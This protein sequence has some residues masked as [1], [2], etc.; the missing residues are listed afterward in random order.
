MNGNIEVVNENLWCVNQHYVHAGYI[1]E[2]TLLPGTSLDK[3]IYLTNQ[4]ILVLN[5]AAPALKS[6]ERCCCVLWGHTDEQ[7]EYAWQK[8]QKVETPDAYANMYLNVLEWEIKRRCV[9]AEY[10]A[11]L[12]KPTLL[13]KFKSKAKKFLE[14]R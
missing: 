8:M 11:S 12:P 13:D 14:R 4:G 7:L 3:E 2:L 6:Q 10:I 9:K 5:T 1:K